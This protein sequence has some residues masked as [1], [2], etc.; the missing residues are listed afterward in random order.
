MGFA[1][2]VTGCVASVESLISSV[3]REVPV[4]ASVLTEIKINGY[5]I[6][7]GANL[8]G[9]DLSGA[10]LSS[11]ELNR[12]TLSGVD[13]SGANLRGA[14]LRGAILPDGSIHK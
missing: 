5:W 4:S 6:G 14:I 1:I 9:V 11:A 2:G 12:A 10:D 13:L 3:V 7:P 8:C